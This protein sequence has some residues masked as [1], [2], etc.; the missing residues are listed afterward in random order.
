MGGCTAAELQNANTLSVCVFMWRAVPGKLSYVPFASLLLS[1]LIILSDVSPHARNQNYLHSERMQPLQNRMHS[2]HYLHLRARARARVCV[3]VRGHACVHTC[4]FVC[5]GFWMFITS[6]AY[7]TKLTITKH[8][9]AASPT[10][11]KLTI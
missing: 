4:V 6:S 8:S 9:N 10:L 1:F 3:C 11:Q 7:A 5:M 2:L